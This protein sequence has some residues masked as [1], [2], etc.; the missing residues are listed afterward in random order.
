MATDYKTLNQQDSGAHPQAETKKGTTGASVPEL[1]VDDLHQLHPNCFSAEDIVNAINKVGIGKRKGTPCCI[2]CYYQS[3]SCCGI[4]SVCS[5]SRTFATKLG[6]IKIALDANNYPLAFPPNVWQWIP[7]PMITFLG[8][9]DMSSDVPFSTDG[10]NIIKVP[11]FSSLMLSLIDCLCASN[12]C[13]Q[14]DGGSV[15]FADDAGVPVVITSG[16]RTGWYV[17]YDRSVQL[18]SSSGI[19]LY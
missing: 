14:V 3:I 5:G 12:G 8:D 19:S 6:V 2:L 9:Y 15:V 13:Q 11:I 4:C 1:G 7:D 10:I 17:R 16:E 18:L